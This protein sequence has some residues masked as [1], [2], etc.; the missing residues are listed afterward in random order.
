[1]KTEQERHSREYR[2]LKEEKE[3]SLADLSK[4]LTQAEDEVSKA[5]C[6][7]CASH[8]CHIGSKIHSNP[9]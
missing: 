3:K 7:K 4:R 6:L 8:I 9:I 1:M 5:V 2:E